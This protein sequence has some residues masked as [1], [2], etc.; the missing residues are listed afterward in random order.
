MLRLIKTAL[1]S[2]AG[3]YLFNLL[4]TPI[5][6]MLGPLTAILIFKQAFKKPTYWP[7]ALREAAQV[8]LG[9]VMGGSFSPDMGLEILHSF[10]GIFLTTF[11]LMIVAILMGSFIS[12]YIGYSYS[13]SVL[14]SIPGGLSQIVVVCD[15]IPGT[16]LTAVTY[17][18]T[19]RLLSV[20]FIVPFLVTH[21]SLA[22]TAQAINNAVDP[23]VLSQADY[24]ILF[25]YVLI[26]TVAGF[27]ARRLRIPTPFL[28]GALL[29]SAIPSL[30]GANVPEM[31]SIIVKAAQISFGA[32]LG[33]S[34]NTQNLGEW[35]KGLAFTLLLSLVLIVCCLLMGLVLTQVYDMDILTAFL[36]TSPGGMSEMAVTALSVNASLSTVTSYQL[37]RFLFVCIVI[38]PFIKWMLTKQ[39][40][41]KQSL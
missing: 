31:P 35:K 32:Y 19:I 27:T 16:D 33:N 20:V 17:M 21:S 3:G 9:F 18:Q 1:I 7:F 37:F 28:L 29:S 24:L 36:A 14:G 38:P 11:I 25:G 4:H 5:P 41:K 12:R 40:S 30:M 6:W 22:R 2:I 15:D 26:A 10:P 39:M 34:M 8:I 13:S 23:T